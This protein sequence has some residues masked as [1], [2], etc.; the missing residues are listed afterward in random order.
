MK[1]IKPFLLNLKVDLA[2]FLTNKAD[3]VTGYKG[4]N[5]ICEFYEDLSLSHYSDMQTNRLIFNNPENSN[6]KD[7]FAHTNANMRNSFV[8]IYHWV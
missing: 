2:T 7:S 8:D 5:R 1:K 4:L 3:C 6:L